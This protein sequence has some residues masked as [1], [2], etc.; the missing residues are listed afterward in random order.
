MLK[1]TKID[2]EVIVEN[3]DEFNE[4]NFSNALSYDITRLSFTATDKTEIGESS[5]INFSCR[6]FILCFDNLY[7]LTADEL[8]ERAN[9]FEIN[10]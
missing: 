4:H 8:V 2:K 9:L 10:I 7:K 6:R 1:E 5:K 3:S